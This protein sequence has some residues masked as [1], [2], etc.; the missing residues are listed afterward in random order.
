MIRFRSTESGLRLLQATL[1]TYFSG[2]R[3]STLSFGRIQQTAFGSSNVRELAL[4]SAFL[5]LVSVAEATIDSLGDELTARDLGD[6]DETIR[7]LV[8]EKELATSSSWNNRRR[9]YQR[10]HGV[11]LRKCDGHDKLEGAIQVRNAIAHGLGHLTTRQILG[12]ET[13]KHLA[14]I[15][16]E[17]INGYLKITPDHVRDCGLYGSRFL[18]SVDE[19]VKLKT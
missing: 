10:H 12:G 19:S 17:S 3:L 5:R 2:T 14:R 15:D 16:I 11:D 18:R 7:L 6:V 9:A 13:A 8:L 4:Q 1:R